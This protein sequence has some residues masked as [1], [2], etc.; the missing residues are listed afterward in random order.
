MDEGDHLMTHNLRFTTGDLLTV[1]DNF[2]Y[3]GDGAYASGPHV[4]GHITAQLRDFKPGNVFL[5]LSDSQE[6]GWRHGRKLYLE[7]MTPIG[8]RMAWS[9]CFKMKKVEDTKS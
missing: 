9:R 3:I 6:A 5:A 2:K 7:V 1:I 8:P 4:R